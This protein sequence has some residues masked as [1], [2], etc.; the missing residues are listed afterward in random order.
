MRP[1]WAYGGAGLPSMMSGYC[2]FW[3]SVADLV[4]KSVQFTVWTFTVI[5]GCA[6]WKAAA[7]AFQYLVVLLD[8][9]V[10]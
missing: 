5:F 8:G 9:P 2:L 10:P 4:G 1:D 6:W 7:M 3:I